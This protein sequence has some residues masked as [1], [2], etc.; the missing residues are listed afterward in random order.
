MLNLNSPTVLPPSPPA[1][2]RG[3]FFLYALLILSSVMV[4]WF[5]KQ[6]HVQATLVEWPEHSLWYNVKRLVGGD[7][8]LLRGEADGRINFL[9]L[10]QGGAKHDGPYLTD[11]IILASLNPETNRLALL[12]IPRDL[13]VPLPRFGLRKINSANAFGEQLESGAGAEFAADVISQVFNLPIHYYVRLDFSGFASIIDQ[14]GGLPITIERTFSDPEY[15]TDNNG[16]TS[17]SFVAG[18]QVLSG[19]QTLAFVRSRHGDNGEGSDFARAKRQQL[20]LLALKDKLLSQATVLNPRLVIRLYRTFGES[21]ETNLE[22]S[23][24]LRLAHLLKQL[25]PEYISNRVLDNTPSGLLRETVGENGAY[26]LVPRVEDYSELKTLAHKML[27]VNLVE[28][29]RARVAIENGTGQAGLAEATAESLKTQGF[30]VIRFGNAPSRDFPRTLLYD[31]SD[32]RKPITR[33]IL[34]SS[35][36]IAAI[37]LE[38]VTGDQVAPDFRL[39]LGAD[40]LNPAR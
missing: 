30:N 24:A 28:T 5:L 27:E 12:S 17:V 20:V 2:T 10:G 9:L 35:F 29:E 32:G 14:L 16:L 40:R 31:Y 22:A 26:I 39:I 1:V 7:D 33:Q 25:E 18:P 6:P 19:E 4:V 21:V 34:E 36:G 11:T 3:K 23:E 37:T 8:K 13:V 38:P 15:P